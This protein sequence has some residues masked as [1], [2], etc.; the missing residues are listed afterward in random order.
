MLALDSNLSGSVICIRRSMNK[1]ESTDTP[2]LEI[3]DMAAKPIHLVLNR[4]MVKILEDM[5]C[6]HD[7]FFRMQDI[8]LTRL[9]AIT[10]DVQS[11]ADFLKYHNVGEGIRLHRMFSRFKGLDVD[12]RKDVFL[13]S[14][15]E[16]VVLRELRLLKH[17]ARI[18][19]REGITLFGIMDETGFLKENEVYVTYDTMGTRFGPP[20]GSQRSLLVTRSPALHPGDIQVA[21]NVIP[22]K[23]HP[24]LDHINVIVF[25]RHGNRDLPSQLSGG[26]LDGDIYNVIWDRGVQPKMSFKA[27]DY[28]RVSPIELD[29]DVTKDDMAE[30]FIEF[31]KSDCLGVIANRHM[32]VAD[33]KE[34]GTPHRDCVKLAELHSTAVDF[35]KTGCRVEM[36]DLPRANRLRPD[37]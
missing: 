35:S 19:V 29:R 31:M 32:I 5:G 22:P 6:N 7:W 20:P 4:Q 17:K 12:Y 18:P 2:N 11:V 28:P 27:A 15:V 8:E 37:L 3:C 34:E 16:A 21:R 30:F 1:F 9:R 33:Q 25:S 10:S 36:R 23:G 13:R 14:V 26:D 24:L